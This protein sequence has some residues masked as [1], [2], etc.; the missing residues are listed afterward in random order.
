MKMIVSSD[1]SAP[2]EILQEIQSQSS[3][4]AIMI[5]I[6]L[7]TSVIVALFFVFLS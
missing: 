3:A 4:N 5:K 7:T 2:L 6:K 1:A